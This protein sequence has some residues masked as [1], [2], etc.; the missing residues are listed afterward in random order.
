[1]APKKGN[2]TPQ[3]QKNKKD[4][5]ES[6]NKNPTGAQSTQTA[7]IKEIFQQLQMQP[8][9]TA[10]ISHTSQEILNLAEIS[11]TSRSS[12]EELMVHP[13]NSSPMNTTG[14]SNE[15]REEDTEKWDMRTYIQ[16]LPTRADM[17]QYVHRLEETYKTEI[18][19]LKTSTKDIQEKTV[20]LDNRVVK[21]EQELIK[22]KEKI[23]KQ[24]NQ[25]NQL[26]NSLDEQENRSR[27]S[28]IRIRGLKE[29]VNPKD[30]IITLQKIFQEIAQDTDIKDLIID[31][32]HR[33]TGRRRLDPSKPRDVICKMH[34]AHIKDRIM[35][36]AR[37]NKNIQYEGDPLLLFQ[38]LSKY[39]L[40]R[41]RALKPLVE[42]LRKN[43][44]QYRWKFP[45]QLQAQREESTATFSDL[46]DLPQFLTILKLS[47]IE[48]PDWPISYMKL[49]RKA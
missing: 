18:Q 33:A 47:D 27:R 23:Q 34:Y 39:T 6:K 45:F 5:I 40:D 11:A 25:I 21:T 30:L 26:I 31:R 28:N 41:R 7:D 49:P 46:E 16:S 1:M 37:Q 44:L 2:K 29:E 43:N 20:K 35:L 12:G 38:D 10:Q 48:L 19:E 36:A 9:R 22:V 32:A 3:P 15:Q 17:D 8:P 13:R 24:G 42:Q 14:A 4:K